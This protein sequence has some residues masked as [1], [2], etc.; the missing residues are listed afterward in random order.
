MRDS[1]PAKGRRQGE[2]GGPLAFLCRCDRTV[3]SYPLSPRRLKQQSVRH[4]VW[5]EDYA[6]G[7]P[8]YEA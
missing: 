2:T 1:R 4:T 6:T 5:R 3:C 8:L 7:V